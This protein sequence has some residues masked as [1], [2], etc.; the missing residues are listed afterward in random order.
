[1]LKKCWR[2]TRYSRKSLYHYRSRSRRVG[3]L[4]GK[5]SETVGFQNRRWDSD[6]KTVRQVLLD[7]VL[8]DIVE[9]EFHFDR[10]NPLSPKQHKETANAG[11]LKDLGLT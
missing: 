1:M 5:R 10:Y 2:E 7:G 11:I 8:G 3:C 9:A 6:L 4:S